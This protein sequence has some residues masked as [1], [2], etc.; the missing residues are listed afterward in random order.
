MI[1]E[2]ELEKLKIL[3]GSPEEYIEV[4][5]TKLTQIAIKNGHKMYRW[6]IDGPRPSLRYSCFCDKC[7]FMMMLETS[8]LSIDPYKINL[9]I[10]DKYL[11]CPSSD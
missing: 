11:I 6:V 3:A 7:Y 8:E 5:R 4:C 10:R 2:E 1:S 9:N